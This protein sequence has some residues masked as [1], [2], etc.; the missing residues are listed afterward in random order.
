MAKQTLN[1]SRRERQLIEALYRLEE[2]S[3]ADV[4]D[5]I[6]DPPSYSSVRAML[7]ELVRKKK[8][9]YR[10]DGKRYLY[11]PKAA[12]EKVA[13]GML[14]NLVANFFRGRASEAICALL[15]DDATQ[16]SAEDIVRIKEQIKQAEAELTDE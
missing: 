10:R 4:R 11:R 6:D 8:I 14:N 3:V 2:A 16:L 15:E 1:L 12:R 7:T 9:A 5:A 13:K